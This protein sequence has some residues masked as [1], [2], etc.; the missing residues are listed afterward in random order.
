MSV[1]VQ[2]AN[3]HREVDS[4]VELDDVLD[5]LAAGDEPV[6]VELTSGS[7]VM[8]V[9][10]GL[11][12]AAVVLFRDA[13]GQPWFARS[14]VGS[15]TDSGSDLEFVKNGTPYR[16]FA[17]AAIAPA[18]MREAAREFVR[19]P[20]ARPSMVTWVS[21]GAGDDTIEGGHDGP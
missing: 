4:V 2:F 13:D 5:G 3:V 10:V 7:A 15:S 11:R 9:G 21:E 12:D 6:L 8:N 17:H 20:G 16:F 1:L 18:E 14:S 19:T